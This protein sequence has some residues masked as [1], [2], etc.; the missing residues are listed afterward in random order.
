M[1]RRTVAGGTARRIGHEL[2]ILHH[3][4]EGIGQ[5]DR[6]VAVRRSGHR[7]GA[8]VLEG[9]RRSAPRHID[10]PAVSRR[11]RVAVDVAQIVRIGGGEQRSGDDHVAMKHGRDRIEAVAAVVGQAE[12]G[13]VLVRHERHAIARAD[14][15][16]EIAE[17]VE[18]IGAAAGRDAA[19]VLR[20]RRRVLYVPELAV[21]RRKARDGG[22]PHAQCG[23]DR[24][25]A[26]P[27]ERE[28]AALPHGA[29]AYAVLAMTATRAGAVQFG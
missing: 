16:L 2:R 21:G 1:C 5:V 19:A 3:R 17:A 14:A 8:A 4:D 29:S 12:A 11:I 9:A 22:S 6:P 25:G 20:P 7:H 10:H 27:P 26:K 28:T 18:R 15:D 23:H 13:E 24:N